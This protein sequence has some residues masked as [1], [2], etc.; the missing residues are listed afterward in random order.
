MSGCGACLFKDSFHEIHETCPAV[1]LYFM[2][3]T[4]FLILAGSAFHQMCIAVPA[5]IIYGEMHFLLI[6]ENELFH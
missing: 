5:L 3:K 2:K 4:L 6:T 1:T